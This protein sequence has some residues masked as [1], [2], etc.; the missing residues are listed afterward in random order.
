MTDSDVEQPQAA[1]KEEEE[2]QNL[3]RKR[4]PSKPKTVKIEDKD[5]S[6]QDEKRTRRNPHHTAPPH[7]T[8]DWND[9]LLLSLV[10]TH[11]RSWKPVAEAYNGAM[12]RTPEQLRS[13]WRSIGVDARDVTRDTDEDKKLRGIVEEVGAK[14]TDVKKA[15][16]D[17]YGVSAEQ[18]GV[19]WR[20]GGFDPVLKQHVESRS[21][22]RRAMGSL[23]LSC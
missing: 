21:M 7:I 18:C 14:W 23:H 11:N 12:S 10:T 3:K 20:K 17:R 15:W 8:R 5:E 6:T 1:I 19:P 13:R 4:T 2:Q 9:A 22:E 16:D